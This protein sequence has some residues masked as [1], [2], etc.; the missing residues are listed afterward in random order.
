[1][2]RPS[3]KAVI[4]KLW[5]DHPNSPLP[6]GR[7]LEG[8]V[9]TGSGINILKVMTLFDH[10]DP[11]SIVIDGGPARVSRGQPG[12]GW[13]PLLQFEPVRPQLWITSQANQQL[14]GM[15]DIPFIRDGIK[16]YRNRDGFDVNYDGYSL[17]KRQADFRLTFCYQ[18]RSRLV[19]LRNET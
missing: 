15:F 6:L 1:M 13:R 9:Y 12:I 4:D 7:I 10:T 2:N 8:R 3:K 11:A 19:V 16:W 18:G 5:P 17:D 14:V